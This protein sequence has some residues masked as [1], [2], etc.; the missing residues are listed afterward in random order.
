MYY[1][2]KITNKINGKIYIGK[3]KYNGTNPL[4]DTYMGS[5]KLITQAIKK[6]GKDNFVK[7]IIQEFDNEND[8]FLLEKELV[9]IEF[10][11]REDTYNIHEGGTGSFSHINNE[12][13]EKRKNIIA[14]KKMIDSG[15][16]KIG[17]KQ[18]FT[19]ETYK[20]LSDF[21]INRWKYWKENPN[22]MPNFKCSSQT[23]KII[24]EKLKGINNP[25]YG[26]HWY[27]HKDSTN[28]NERKM[29]NVNEIPTDYILLSEWKDNQKNKKSSAYGKHWYNDGINNYFLFPSD[30]KVKDLIKGRIGNLF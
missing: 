29:F 28:I 3:R 27:I 12:I 23:K 8:A 25:N 11:Q 5:G 17:G 6:Y 20:K 19:N 14:L 18:Y 22:K 30:D 26:K 15:E 2:Y 9:D 21:N 24:A 16:L 4:L 13:I 10:C 7:E 1:V